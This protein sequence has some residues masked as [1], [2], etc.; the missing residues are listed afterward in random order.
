MFSSS[1]V[2]QLSQTLSKT[3]IKLTYVEARSALSIAWVT[4]NQSSQRHVLDIP[5]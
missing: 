4:C 3:V 2:S 5:V 1:R